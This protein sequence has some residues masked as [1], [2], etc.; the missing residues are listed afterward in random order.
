LQAEVLA[1]R[2]QLEQSQGQVM[3]LQQQQLTAAQS[4]KQQG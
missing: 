2:M 1:L 3:Q 4:G